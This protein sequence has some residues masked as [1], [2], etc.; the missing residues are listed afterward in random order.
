MLY[1]RTPFVVPDLSVVRAPRRFLTGSAVNVIFADGPTV[2]DHLPVPAL[3]YLD[4]VTRNFESRIMCVVELGKQG[5]APSGRCISTRG[6]SPQVSRRR[7]RRPHARRSGACISWRGVRA[8]RST[9]SPN[10]TAFRRQ[11]VATSGRLGDGN[12]HLHN[13]I[14]SLRRSGDIHSA[15]PRGD[16]FVRPAIAPVGGDHVVAQAGSPACTTL[17]VPRA[18]FAGISPDRRSRPR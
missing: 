14:P 11:S 15:E 16:H 8:S 12:R 2:Q 18:R 1:L 7:S 13:G 10:S 4:S 17:L 6:R 5:S 3:T 9:R